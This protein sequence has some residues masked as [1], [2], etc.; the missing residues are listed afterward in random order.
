MMTTKSATAI[1]AATFLS[2]FISP[3]FSAEAPSDEIW[4]AI[5]ATIKGPA[6]AA[7][8]YYGTLN[9]KVLEG[10]LTKTTPSS[11]LKLS[12]AG[13]MEGGKMQWLPEATQSGTTCGYSDVMYL[14]IETVT[15]IV[16][17]DK[18]FVKNHLLQIK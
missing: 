17:L 13:W 14:R 6:T 2:I 12:H 5:D 10:T 18:N 15:R 9:K 4:V 16:E 8:E 11:F 3:L 1:L 7:V